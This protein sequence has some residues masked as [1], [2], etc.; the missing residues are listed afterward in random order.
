MPNSHATDLCIRALR[1]EAALH[2]MRVERDRW[3]FAA[4][5]AGT[6]LRKKRCAR[7]RAGLPTLAQP[8]TIIRNRG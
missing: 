5:R 3:R 4:Q 1:L 8:H 6:A 7:P 2:A